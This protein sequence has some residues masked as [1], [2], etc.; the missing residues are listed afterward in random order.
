MTKVK[1]GYK[2][3]FMIVAVISC[4]MIVCEVALAWYMSTAFTD[5]SDSGVKVIGTIDLEVKYDF[6]FYND[7]LSP[8]TYY[9]QNKNNDGPARTTIKTTDSNNIDEVFVK[10]K[11]ITDTK[12][13]SLFFDG[14]LIPSS[15]TE[16]ND[17]TKAQ[18]LNNWYN[19]SYTEVDKGEGVKHYEYI[20]YYI[21]L[22]G[23]TEVTF[24]EGFYVN[25]H[26]DNS[27]AK[28]DVYI[29]MEIYGLQS[30][31]G[32]YLE[33]EDWLDAPAVFTAFASN[34]TGE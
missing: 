1:N 25:N 14:N 17:D 29:K 5:N 3:I 26:I 4:M 28:D 21:G 8:D 2:L 9:L 22:V 19:A 33:A 27:Y 16:Y 13:L 15:I 12:Q 7:A 24:N 11:F 30:Q 18:C 20:Y 34:P 10:V 32:A 31:Y 6:S 23:S